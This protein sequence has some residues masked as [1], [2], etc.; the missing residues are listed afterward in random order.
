MIASFTS[1]SGEIAIQAEETYQLNDLEMNNTTKSDDENSLDLPSNPFEV[2]D[3]IR[4]STIMDNATNP[5][6]A[7]DEALKAFD[8]LENSEGL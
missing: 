4:R 2:M 6:D 5:S 1:I 8:M 3:I 7:I